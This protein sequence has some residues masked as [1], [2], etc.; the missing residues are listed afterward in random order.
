MGDE[1]D[2]QSQETSCE[3]QKKRSKIVF[4]DPSAMNSDSQAVNDDTS[5]LLNKDDFEKYEK[6][7]GKGLTATR[8]RGRPKGARNKPKETPKVKYDDEKTWASDE[9]DHQKSRSLIKKRS[10]P[11][12]SAM[13]EEFDSDDEYFA[14][15]EAEIA[16]EEI[17][18]KKA[19]E[20][21]KMQKSLTQTTHSIFR[22]RGRGRGRP[23]AEMYQGLEHISNRVTKR[24]M[25]G[26]DSSHR[27]TTD[28]GIVRTDLHNIQ[29]LDQ[30]LIDEIVGPEPELDSNKDD[31]EV[32]LPPSP[33]H[34]DQAMDEGPQAPN[35]E[36]EQLAEDELY[37]NANILRMDP[38]KLR[39]RAPPLNLPHS[40]GDLCCPDNYL[41]DLLSLYEPFRCYHRV[42]R[43]SPIRVEDFI[44][45]LTSP[46]DSCLLAEVH[47][48]LMRALLREDDVT[49]TM[50]A[51]SDSRESA[52]LSL[53]LLDRI[54]WP[55]LLDSYLTSILKSES[56]A[57]RASLAGPLRSSQGR[58][59]PNTL[60]GA[61]PEPPLDTQTFG[62]IEHLSL[63]TRMFVAAM[64]TQQSITVLANTN[65]SGANVAGG[66]DKFLSA[67][68]FTEDVIP[69]PRDYPRVH[70]SQRIAL[71]Q[72][73]VSLFMATGPV[74]TEIMRVTLPPHEDFCRICHLSGELLCCERCTAVFH[75][76]CFNPPIKEVP[77]SSWLCP[78]CEKHSALGLDGLSASEK[79]L[80][81]ARKTPLGT[82]RAGRIYWHTARRIVVEVV[83]YF[84]REPALRGIQPGITDDWEELSLQA[85]V[86]R[87]ESGTCP[88]SLEPLSDDDDLEAVAHFSDLSTS[89]TDSDLSLDDSPSPSKTKKRKRFYKHRCNPPI[90]YCDEP[91]AYYYSTL[92][93]VQ[94]LRQCLSPKWEPL[95][96]HRL[97]K[98]LAESL[99]DEMAITEQITKQGFQDF[100][101]LLDKHE[102]QLGK[103]ATWPV[104]LE[105][106]AK[107]GE[108][109]C[110]RNSLTAPMDMSPLEPLSGDESDHDIK[111]PTSSPIKLKQENADETPDETET[112]FT[113]LTLEKL[114]DGPFEL[115][116]VNVD[117]HQLRF[118]IH[119]T[120]HSQLEQVHS[121]LTEAELTEMMRNCALPSKNSEWVKVVGAGVEKMKGVPYRVGDEGRW[122]LWLNYYSYEYGILYP[123][124]QREDIEVNI[125]LSKKQHLE[126]RERRKPLYSKFALIEPFTLSNW[127]WIP[128]VTN[129]ENKNWD[130]RALQFGPMDSRQL[131]RTIKLT[132][133]YMEQN[134]PFGTLSPVWMAKREEW[135]RALASASSSADLAQSVLALESVIRPMTMHRTWNIG[136][137]N[138]TLDRNTSAQRDEDKR[139]R[140]MDRNNS[141][142]SG[143]M[144]MQLLARAIKLGHE[145][146]SASLVTTKNRKPI[147]HTVWKFK[148]EEYRRVGGDGWSWSAS[149]RPSLD[150]LLSKPRSPPLQ[151]H[152]PQPFA[153]NAGIQHGL[154]WTAMPHYL[155]QE[156]PEH[157]PKPSE[158]RGHVLQPLTGIPL[159]LSKP[160]KN[161]SIPPDQIYIAP[162]E[163]E[164]EP[165]P[166]LEESWHSCVNV[167][168]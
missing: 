126:E 63:L 116:S 2:T 100:V 131:V 164:P 149:C 25:P 8:G 44:A 52:N 146:P 88:T 57:K 140:F 46:D 123:P 75:L 34:F 55:H 105:Q 142:V 137:G 130:Q 157:A 143:F 22:G 156:K 40:T 42:L 132:L 27:A 64:A 66:A 3:T 104:L 97:D 83:D 5:N 117:Q 125:A 76:K 15:L 120:G 129:K 70:I 73:L 39:R 49:G 122:K 91:K 79:I 138:L 101:K 162:H 74:R 168:R 114:D 19:R 103:V 109:I 110:A 144:D 167:S 71:L 77:S 106:E 47:I 121:V 87:R 14:R 30:N 107:K 1:E 62:S 127:D 159:Y 155:E 147:K 50:H 84:Q 28:R 102:P 94:V 135:F 86:S 32:P 163:D 16:Q 24:I 124:N 61:S 145:L 53:Y 80:Y 13:D 6:M 21:K 151:F 166:K 153:K 4:L 72:G 90:A 54:T 69:L 29:E 10:K 108:Q 128:T 158:C 133:A 139:I 38:A 96:C 33:S 89:C 12:K 113:S 160:R 161:Y 68:M 98:L 23:S 115:V 41:L 165:N 18:N 67:A 58:T 93:Q 152:E 60:T 51:V 95:L 82:D 17:A 48:C 118:P 9:S 78:V 37:L 141:L 20:Q 43:I 65:P 112:K 136:L 99:A 92:A 7:L 134:L 26:K 154:G 11:K 45:A 36:S 35:L 59:T 119:E 148:G 111:P 31:H 56:A 150:D 85:A 81:S